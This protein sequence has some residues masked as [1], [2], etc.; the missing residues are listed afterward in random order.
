MQGMSKYDVL[1][2]AAKCNTKREFRKRFPDA[3]RRAAQKK[4]LKDVEREISNNYASKNRNNGKLKNHRTK[5]KNMSNIFE[6]HY[7]NVVQP[8]AKDPN[9]ILLTMSPEK[10]HLWHMGP[11]LLGEVIEMNFASPEDIEELKKE[12]GDIVFYVLGISGPLNLTIFDPSEETM[13]NILE[14][15]VDD[16]QSFNPAEKMMENA[17]RVFTFIKRF[18]IYNKPVNL[19]DEVAEGLQNIINLVAIISKEF[20]HCTVEDVLQANKEKLITGTNARYQSGTYSDTEANTRADE[21]PAE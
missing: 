20:C 14:S 2:C 9:Q 15:L 17:E 3:Y 12:L 18:C 13:K 10:M 4:W 7:A 16:E 5:G 19:A 21:T 8:L 11:A 1:V 6:Q